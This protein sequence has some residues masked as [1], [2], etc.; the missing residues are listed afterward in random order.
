MTPVLCDG[1]TTLVCYQK[2]RIA[3]FSIPLDCGRQDFDAVIH[4]LYQPSQ[5]R[6][7]CGSIDCCVLNECTGYRLV[8]HG[9]ANYFTVLFC[10]WNFIP[11][12]QN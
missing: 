12:D 7:T 9:I 4:V 1:L 3:V 2:F 5:V 6:L 8:A 10:F 11:L